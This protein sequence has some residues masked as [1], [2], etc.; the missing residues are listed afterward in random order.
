MEDWK[1]QKATVSSSNMYKRAL[2]RFSGHSG[3]Y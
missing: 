2:V 1:S 3:G